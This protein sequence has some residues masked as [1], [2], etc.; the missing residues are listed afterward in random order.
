LTAALVIKVTVVGLRGANVTLSHIGKEQIL[1][2]NVRQGKSVDTTNQR[3]ASRVYQQLSTNSMT[4]QLKQ[5]GH[6][7]DHVNG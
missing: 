5:R 7:V 6:R 1:L 4:C 2:D 3:L